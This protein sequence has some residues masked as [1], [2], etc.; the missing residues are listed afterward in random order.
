M[1]EKKTMESIKD[2]FNAYEKI[3]DKEIHYVYFKEN[4][5]QEIVFKPKKANFM[6]LCGIS[7][8]GMRPAQFY[9]AL[10][11]NKVSPKNIIKKSDGSTD[12]KLQ[13]IK[14]LNE[15]TTCNIR[16]I[17]ERSSYL[18]FSFDKGI[19]SRKLIFCLA[20]ERINSDT[21]APTSLL[22]LKSNKG[23]TVKN[24]F[25][26]HCIYSVDSSSKDIQIMCKSSEF[27]QYETNNTYFYK[28]ELERT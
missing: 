26:V 24:G 28:N 9:N 23:K 2:G 25:P 21:F 17:D 5:Y 8:K 11:T 7:Y 14:Y 13:I 12:Q 15:L 19:R 20:I 16:I 18:N 10:K 4:K 1:D 3:V 6:H 22:N 27:M